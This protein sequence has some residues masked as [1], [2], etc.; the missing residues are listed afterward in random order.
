MRAIFLAIGM[1]M[2]AGAGAPLW[3][4]APD[5]P[6]Y[7]PEVLEDCLQGKEGYEARASCIGAASDDCM[8][9]PSGQTTVGMVQ[10]L[11]LEATDWDNRLTATYHQLM[12]EQKAADDE[13]AALGSAVKPERAKRL[14]Q[15]ERQWIAFRDGACK[16]EEAQWDGGSGS[17]PAVNGCVMT[18]TG[19]QALYLEQYLKADN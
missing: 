6:D 16:F 12:K 10:C 8:T 2:A 18:L 19:R 9:T 5:R 15:M 3:A 14:Q 17:G 4:E 1:T 13:L 7:H 11:S